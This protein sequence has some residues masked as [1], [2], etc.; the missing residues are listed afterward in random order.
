MPNTLCD[1]V[2]ICT[3][4]YANSA[5]ASVIGCVILANFLKFLR[6]VED[7]PVTCCAKHIKA[8]STPQLLILYLIRLEQ[9]SSVLM[10]CRGVK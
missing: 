5:T 7:Q 3:V 10:C 2:L 9:S 6:L 8:R 1:A 4:Y